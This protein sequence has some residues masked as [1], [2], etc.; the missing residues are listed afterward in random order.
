MEY[1]GASPCHSG[2]DQGALDEA[3]NQNKANKVSIHFFNSHLA[4]FLGKIALY[5]GIGAAAVAFSPSVV[6][7]PAFVATTTLSTAAFSVPV[8]AIVTSLGA[9]LFIVEILRKKKALLY[10]ISLLYTLSGNKDWWNEI[11]PNLVL[12]AIPLGPDHADRLFFDADVDAVLTMLEDFELEEGLVQPVSS[13]EWEEGLGASHCH[14][15]AVDFTGVPVDQIQQGVEFLEKRIQEK[16]KVYVHC[17]AG[18]GRSATIVIAYLLK[19]QYAGT[20][21]D[22]ETAFQDVHDQVKNKRPQINLNAGQRAT[23]RDYYQQQVCA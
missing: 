1:I 11:T 2:Y 15:K 22:F 9:A 14:I 18:R 19:E 8:V 13:Q 4:G 7:I 12:G 17:K 5:V 10:E 6:V 21:I 23:I 16:E 20:N 3:A